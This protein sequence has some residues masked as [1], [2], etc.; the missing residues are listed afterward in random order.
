[1]QICLWLAQ[2]TRNHESCVIFLALLLIC[3]DTLGSQ[4]PFLSPCSPP[5][6]SVS[7]SVQWGDNTQLLY[8]ES[9]TASYFIKVLGRKVIL[10]LWLLHWPTHFSQDYIWGP[11]PIWGLSVMVDL[12]PLL[13]RYPST[14]FCGTGRCREA[15]QTLFVCSTRK[16]FSG[17]NKGSHQLLWLCFLFLKEQY[18][19]I[20]AQPA[21][22]TA[23]NQSQTHSVSTTLFLACFSPPL[24]SKFG[25]DP[26]KYWAP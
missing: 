19:Y 25:L 3:S 21:M 20:A 6:A 4:F 13:L 5:C 8:K 11:D 24:C 2:G 10:F 17:I 26:A 14:W 1:M 16:D 7:P 9:H 15:R 22:G 23:V 12:A 18:V